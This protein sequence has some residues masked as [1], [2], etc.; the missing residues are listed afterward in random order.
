MRFVGMDDIRSTLSQPPP[1][2]HSGGKAPASLGNF[3][4][5]DA[6]FLCPA[7]QQRIPNRNQF[8]SVPA[9]EQTPQE[10]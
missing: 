9:R 10:Q 3:M 7:C 5:D 1:D 6:R 2:R 8:G 4:D